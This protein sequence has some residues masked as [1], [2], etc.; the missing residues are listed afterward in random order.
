MGRQMFGV[1]ERRERAHLGGG[2]GGLQ[3]HAAN[4]QRG[5]ASQWFLRGFEA[6]RMGPG[7]GGSASK[8]QAPQTDGPRS[9]GEPHPMYGVVEEGRASWFFKYCHHDRPGP[10]PSRFRSTPPPSLSQNHNI[11]VSQEV[12]AVVWKGC[13][14]CCSTFYIYRANAKLQFCQVPPSF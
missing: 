3:R 2:V 4:Y 14:K 8:H 12:L 6:S 10:G 9:L 7:E 11:G 5:A 13:F 1:D